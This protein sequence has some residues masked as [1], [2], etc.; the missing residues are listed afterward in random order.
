MKLSARQLLLKLGE[1]KGRYP[2]AWRLLELAL[3]RLGV[4]LLK[5]LRDVLDLYS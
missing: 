4:C 2:A 1:A 3:Q 5:S